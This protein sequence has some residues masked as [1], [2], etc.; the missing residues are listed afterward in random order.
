MPGWLLVALG[1]AIGGSARY[2]VSILGAR[3]LGLEFPWGTLSVNVIGSGLIG[4]LSAS[5]PVDPPSSRLFWMT[6]ICGGFTTFSAFSLETLTLVRQGE[7]AKAVL[8]VGASLL[9][10]GLAVAAGAL[11]G[12]GR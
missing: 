4:W 12:R 6:G 7:A 1:S 8:Y 10:C 9:V 3:W 2:G 5:V 11:L